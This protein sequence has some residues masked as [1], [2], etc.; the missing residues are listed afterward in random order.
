MILIPIAA[1]FP[2]PVSFA[3]FGIG[4][5]LFLS[6]IAIGAY[7][8]LRTGI[9]LN[10]KHEAGFTSRNRDKIIVAVCS[11]V[12]TAIILATVQVLIWHLTGKDIQLLGG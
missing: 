6:A 10:Y 8:F 7:T 1:G 12:G 9:V 3:F 4:V 5:A 11:A 2:S